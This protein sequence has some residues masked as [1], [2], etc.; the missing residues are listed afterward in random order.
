MVQPPIPTSM[1]STADSVYQ[2]DSPVV[3][4]PGEGPLDSAQPPRLKR[5]ALVAALV[6]AA[7]V[8]VVALW[9]LGDDSRPAPDPTAPAP[10]MGLL[11][12]S[13]R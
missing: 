13:E 4:G 10:R 2:P 5:P 11:V 12:D 1:P 3:L 8:A 9:R 6:L 7:L